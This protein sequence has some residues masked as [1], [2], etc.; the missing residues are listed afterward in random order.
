MKKFLILASAF[1]ILPLSLLAFWTLVWKFLTWMWC[2]HPSSQGVY[3]FGFFATIA[4]LMCI[5]A[6]FMEVVEN[7]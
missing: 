5:I 6:Y 3:F 7:D 4:S 1:T 2:I